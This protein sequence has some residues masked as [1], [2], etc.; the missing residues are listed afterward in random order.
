MFLIGNKSDL[1]DKRKISFDEGEKLKEKCGFE[2][3][4]ETSAKTGFNAERLFVAAAKFL[5]WNYNEY[6]KLRQEEGNKNFMLNNKEEDDYVEN[7][8]NESCC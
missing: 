2:L 6:M 5:T 7:T 8:N 4:M 1:E 3:F